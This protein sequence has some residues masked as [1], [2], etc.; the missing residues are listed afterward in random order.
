MTTARTR[1]ARRRVLAI[2]LVEASLTA[3]IA[4]SST[5]TTSSSGNTTGGTQPPISASLTDEGTPVDGG[6]LRIGIGAESDGWNPHVNKWAQWGST[7]GS[8]MLEPLAVLDEKFAAKPW[9]ATSFTPNATYDEWT[10]ELRDDVTFHNGEKFDATAAKLNIEDATKAVLSSVAVAGLFKDITVTGP[11]SLRVQLQ[12]PWAAFPTSFLA[13]Q[14]AMMMAPAMLKE[15]DA[16]QKH[17]IGTGPFA[18][19]E[20][21]TDSYVRVKKNPTYWRKGEPH[22]DQIEFRI[23]ADENSQSNAL[24][25]NDVNVFFTTSAQ[26]AKQLEDTNQ[27]VKN[28]RTEPNEV[29]ANAAAEVEGK[30]NPMANQHARLAIAHATDQKAIAEVMGEGVE[31][32]TSP[33]AP[34]NPWGQP[35]DQNGYPGFDLAK[36]KA[37]VEAYKKDTGA[38]D[39]TV[40]VIGAAG[41][42]NN[43]VLQLLESQWKAAGITTT[44]EN[45]E[46]AVQIQRTITGNYQLSLFAHLTSPEPDQDWYFWSSTTAPGAGGININFSQF[47]SPAIDAALKKGRETADVATRKASYAELV[48]LLNAQAL[49]VWLYWTPYSLVAANDVHGLKAVAAVPF[50]NFQPKNWFGQLWVSR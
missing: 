45:I 37:E 27:I 42:Q 1:T 28:W 41:T 18:F 19:D 10:L 32:P 33:F 49:N 7:V 2:G 6:G 31:T 35:Y 38:P 17:P 47:K 30:P 9:L 13:G 16:G 23:L 8:S 4:C 39:L 21:K 26:T 3:A 50:A 20:W 46:P 24:R 43:Q 25:A 14:S 34:D 5:T 29:L 44:I 48:K 36:A 40:K 12:Q 22:L 11:Y 15:P